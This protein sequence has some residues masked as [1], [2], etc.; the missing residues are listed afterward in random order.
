MEYIAH[1]ELEQRRNRL[2]NF[3]A[4]IQFVQKEIKVNEAGNISEKTVEECSTNQ[5]NLEIIRLFHI[6]NCDVSTIEEIPKYSKQDDVVYYFFKVEFN[7]Q[8][9]I[10]IQKIIERF[11]AEFIFKGVSEVLKN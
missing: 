2:A 4:T 3:K 8:H 7:T 11:N 10:D 9:N 5:R 1:L 6:G